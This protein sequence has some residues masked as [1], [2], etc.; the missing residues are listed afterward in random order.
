[1]GIHLYAVIV[2]ILGINSDRRIPLYHLAGWG[3]PAIVVG[4]TVGVAGINRYGRSGFCWFNDRWTMIG[5]FLIPVAVIMAANCVFFVVIVTKLLMVSWARSRHKSGLSA[6]DI[7]RWTEL[8]AAVS[9]SVLLGLSWIFGAFVD[10]GIGATGS[11]VFQYL[12]AIFTTIQGFIIFLVYCVF[13][14]QVR[15]A[16][17][18]VVS[19]EHSTSSKSHTGGGSGSAG[20][21]LQSTGIRPAGLDQVV[22]SAGLTELS[23]VHTDNSNGSNSVGDTEMQNDV[24]N[25]N[26]NIRPSTAYQ[27]KLGFLRETSLP[28]AWDEDTKNEI[29]GSGAG[30]GVVASEQQTTAPPTTR[31]SRQSI[32]RF[33]PHTKKNRWFPARSLIYTAPSGVPYKDGTV[34][35]EDDFEVYVTYRERSPSARRFLPTAKPLSRQASGAYDSLHLPAS[36]QEKYAKLMEENSVMEEEN[37]EPATMQ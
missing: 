13:N 33:E 2:Q 21:V 10:T 18:R 28:S 37:A 31:G 26:K 1:M 27:P 20:R 8:R 30:G 4:V 34:S 24:N 22:S 32:S 23:N 29:A 3:L 15:A 7:R 25:M 5:S 9:I 14:P 19:G 11:L 12:F 16:L 17:R 6:V 35:G 36:A